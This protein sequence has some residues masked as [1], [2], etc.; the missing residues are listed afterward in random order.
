MDLLTRRCSVVY[1]NIKLRCEYPNTNRY[2]RYGGR[3]IECRITLDEIKRLWLRDDAG[4]LK[5]P[6]IDRIDN[7]GHY[8]FENCRFIEFLENLKRR[9]PPRKCEC[10]A[11]FTARKL[12]HCLECSKRIARTKKC[13][14]CGIVFVGDRIGK[15]LCPSC[16]Y[17]TKPCAFCY[18]PITRS[19][20]R[21][22]NLFRNDLW[23]C[24]RKHQG[25][26]L[27]RLSPTFKG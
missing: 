5:R 7:D 10:G 16:E 13:D 21:Q 3:G 27:H 23:F 4:N 6:S 19:R 8:T 9:F 2:A 25:S 20:T 18:A 26:W 12:T 15:K 11:I 14:E 1:R 17:V 24:S 22:S